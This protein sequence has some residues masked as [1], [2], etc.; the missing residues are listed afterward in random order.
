MPVSD[1]KDE[2]NRYQASKDAAVIAAHK[3]VRDAT[4][5]T[6]LLSVLNNADNPHSMMDRAMATISELFCS[7]IVILLDPASSGTFVPY[8]SL[9]LPV[10][11][12]DEPISVSDP[13][14][15][16]Q[17][18]Q[19]KCALAIDK[20]QRLPLEAQLE[21]LEASAVLYLPVMASYA[22]RGVLIL[23]RLEDVPFTQSDIALL[24]TMAHRVGQ[25]IE[26]SHRRKQLEQIVHSVQEINL[27][28]EEDDIANKAVSLLPDLLGADSVSVALFDAEGATSIRAKSGCSLPEDT[29]LQ[30]ILT[31][32][33]TSEELALFKPFNLNKDIARPQPFHTCEEYC[34]ID[35]WGGLLALPVGLNRLE[36]V[37]LAFREQGIA[38]DP[39][40]IQ[41]GLLYA[42]KISSALDTNRLY[43]AAETEIR[44]RRKAEAALKAS[45]ERLRALIRSVDD[46]IIVLN[47]LG[48]VIFTN[49]AATV[50]WPE[51]KGTT[52]PRPF[53]P[54]VN[55]TDKAIFNNYLQNLI[56]QVGITKNSSINLWHPDGTLHAYDVVM[57]NRLT[58]P[59]VGGIVIT[60][61]DV[62]E[63]RHYEV[64]LEKLAFSDR[65]T[66]L[67]NRA[68]FQDRL[69]KVMADSTDGREKLITVI[70]FDLDNFKIVN[71]SL[72]HEAGDIVL[73]T[74]ADRLRQ[75][76][77]SS[78]MAARLGG[79]EFTLL[80]GEGSDLARAKELAMRLL[81]EIE[82]PIYTTSK[83]VRVG[84]SFGI[85]QGLVG[86]DTAQ[87]LLRKADIA[88]YQAKSKGKNIYAVY[89]KSFEI[90]SIKHLD[91]EFDLRRAI[92]EHEIVVFFQPIVSLENHRI[93]GAEALARWQHPD[94]GLIGPLDFI[95]LAEKTGL[96]A[97]LGA[98]IVD[99]TLKQSNAW[100]N[101]FGSPLP[102]SINLSPLQ[103]V[104]EDFVAAMKS[105]LQTHHVA[106][107]NIIL[108]ITESTL[109]H[110]TSQA[111]SALKQL[112]QMGF[113]IAI[114]DFGT[115]YCN[116]SYLKQLPLDI[117]K[118]DRS[119]IGQIH[120][121][122]HD[123]K[124]TESIV[125]MGQSMGLELVVEG[126]EHEE[127]AAILAQYGCRMSQGFLFAPAMP[128]KEFETL[129]DKLASNK[130]ERISPQSYKQLR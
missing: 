23:A 80:L 19:E 28:L 47:R 12:D 75:T 123:A 65:L 88:M 22:P 53:W 76:I 5:L 10:G 126:I 107:N 114:D 79:D 34:K 29:E 124:L 122:R 95:P 52:L 73:K 118:I 71:D 60:M 15:I 44:D 77:D 2:Q 59:A 102:I 17:V 20:S 21:E 112:K 7:D 93:I 91:A 50:F 35:Q 129:Y 3:A 67:S 62:T 39:D 9:G 108:E 89:Q 49:P 120:L 101:K 85:A 96:I 90:A 83:T 18:M 72:G 58:D 14:N 45:E 64:E 46:L 125:R 116:L 51:E 130:T 128:A 4:R 105:T 113:K 127:Q 100:T 94:K 43:R 121:D 117:L 84:A 26:Q 111:I 42:E 25:A 57:T 119:F 74:V 40:L 97:Q 1:A 70:F 54:C 37:I 87:E 82:R 24:S 78:D 86:Q 33:R 69:N 55:E 61:H 98:Q 104:A 11:M 6:R 66:E 36:G 13:G 92:T 109:I 8:V 68:Y 63:R 30:S 16:N 48:E 81:E 41:I 31:F 56:M 99:M 103:I 27:L 32:L 115:G 110:D 106:A 38:F